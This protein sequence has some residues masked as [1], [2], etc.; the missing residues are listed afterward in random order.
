M[1]NPLVDDWIAYCSAESKATD[2][3]VAAAWEQV[4]DLLRRD[5]EAGWTLTLELIAAAPDDNTL[6]KVA[7]GPLEDLLKHD[8]DR[9]SSESTYRLAGMRSFDDALPECGGCR[10]PS[11]SV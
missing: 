10:R 5:P 1:P 9:S 8:P 11:G 2:L 3:R 6:A 7:A 4:N